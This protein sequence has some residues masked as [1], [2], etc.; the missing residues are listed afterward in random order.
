MAYDVCAADHCGLLSQYGQNWTSSTN[1]STGLLY[2]TKK[3]IKS[4]V[5]VLTP[6][7]RRTHGL[8]D[9]IMCEM[10]TPISR[11][12]HGLTDIIVYEVLTPISRRT[13]GL[14]DIIVYEMLTPISRRTD[15]HDHVRGADNN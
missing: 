7:S 1:F 15:R 12:T 13:H 5:Q 10:L 6:I 14:T 2:Q 9:I 3:R 4:T 11:R 8:T